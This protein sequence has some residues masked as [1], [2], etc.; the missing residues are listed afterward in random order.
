MAKSF[1]IEYHKLPNEVQ[2]WGSLWKCSIEGYEVS[3]GK[4]K[5]GEE[6]LSMPGCNTLSKNAFKKRWKKYTD[7][8]Q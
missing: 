5:G 6:C 8:N 7:K 4:D 2:A 3:T 1:Y